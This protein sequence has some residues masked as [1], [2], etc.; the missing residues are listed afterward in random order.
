M[1]GFER[2]KDLGIVSVVDSVAHKGL[3]GLRGGTFGD[4]SPRTAQR[5]L[6]DELRFRPSLFPSPGFYD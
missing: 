2:L 5:C 6:V 4:K 3:Q 1:Q